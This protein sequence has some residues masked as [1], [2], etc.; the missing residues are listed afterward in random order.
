MNDKIQFII[1][2]RQENDISRSEL[3]EKA[4]LTR[5]YLGKIERCEVNPTLT[6][7]DK[8]AVAMEAKLR[9]ISFEE[10]GRW[11]GLIKEVQLDPKGWYMIKD[12]ANSIGIKMQGGESRST[13][14][15]AIEL[16]KKSRIK[17]KPDLK[18][19]GTKTYPF[20]IL[21]KAFQKKLGAYTSKRFKARYK[22]DNQ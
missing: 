19:A 15:I 2:Y 3:A 10:Q 5:A 9:Y 4:G 1:D 20:K 13:S 22:K 16:C 8:L 11:D 18:I 14:T 6:T 12:Y 17:P 21:E 7:L